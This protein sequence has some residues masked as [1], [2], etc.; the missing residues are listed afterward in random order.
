MIEEE[1]YD[2]D[3]L[4]KFSEGKYPKLIFTKIIT[5]LID[6]LENNENSK[7]SFKPQETKAKLEKALCL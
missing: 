4:T 3:S 5:G 2:S 7:N 1:Y 6:Y